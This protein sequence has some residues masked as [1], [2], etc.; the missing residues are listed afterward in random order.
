MKIFFDENFSENLARGFSEFQS[1]RPSEGVNVHHV[2]KSFGRGTDDNI[3]IPKIAQMH[4]VVI[5]QDLNINRTQ[6]L[7]RLCLEYKLGVFF[8]K[9]QRKKAINIGSGL[10]KS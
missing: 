1:G 2:V 9:P 7:F 6:Y 8:F 5:T 3:W 4:G 10:N